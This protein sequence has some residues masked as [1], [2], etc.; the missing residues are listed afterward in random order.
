[1]IV[2]NNIGN[3]IT[4]RSIKESTHFHDLTDIQ[5]APKQILV[6]TIKHGTDT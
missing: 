1:M 5:D 2:T 6:L 3:I 4:M